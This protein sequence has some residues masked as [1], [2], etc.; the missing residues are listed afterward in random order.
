MSDAGG[1]IRRVVSTA[2]M[3]HYEISGARGR[4]VDGNTAVSGTDIPPMMG[5]PPQYEFN[6]QGVKPRKGGVWGGKPRLGEAVP[7]AWRVGW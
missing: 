6:L 4:V 5:F 2:P 7:P 3:A 1:R